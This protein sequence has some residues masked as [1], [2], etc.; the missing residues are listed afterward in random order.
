VP[1]TW[2]QRHIKCGLWWVI[3]QCPR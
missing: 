1:R 3:T 2:F